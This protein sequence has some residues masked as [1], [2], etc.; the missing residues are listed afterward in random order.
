MNPHRQ[1][2]RWS[3]WLGW[4][5]DSN[6]TDATLFIIYVLLK[7]LAS[8]LILVCMY[9]AARA[10]GGPTRVPL[11]FLAF[12][13]VGNVCFTLIG[14]T[15]FGMSHSVLSD[16]E[17]YRML[18][19]IYISPARLQTYLLGRSLSGAA[20][21]L[22]GGLINLGV[23]L[24]AFSEVRQA[25]AQ[26]DTEWGWLLIYLIVGI[27]MLLAFG[28]CL[29]AIMLQVSRQ[30]YYLHEGLIGMMYLMSGVVFPIGILPYPLQ[31]VGQM[32]PPTYW[33][34]GMRRSL[35]GPP[36]EAMLQSPLSSWSHPQLFGALL[37]STII[38]GTVSVLLFR[39]SE[40]KAYQNGLFDET[41]G[42]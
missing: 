28:L 27:I 31:I 32:L 21:A 15:M 41:T 8:S 20:Q 42:A 4:Q 7:P 3:T 19:Y 25:F 12:V 35:L 2:F 30:G 29:A 16:R 9:Y 33:L 10:A 1:T 40:R 18:K 24:L 22:L 23:G 6:W 34:E 38:L 36:T 5:L 39:W 11:D 26:H 13:Y 14:A 17:Y 37:L